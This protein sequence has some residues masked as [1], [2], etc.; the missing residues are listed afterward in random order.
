M[1]LPEDMDLAVDVTKCIKSAP[2][3]IRAD[4]FSSWMPIP[5]FLEYSYLMLF[6]EFSIYMFLA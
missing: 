1:L 6:S 2:I 5:F 4:F 3:I